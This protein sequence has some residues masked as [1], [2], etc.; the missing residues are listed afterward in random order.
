MYKKLRKPRRIA[1]SKILKLLAEL[2][3]DDRLAVVAAVFREMPKNPKAE[4]RK[5]A[6]VLI[7]TAEADEQHYRAVMYGE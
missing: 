2:S 7:A 6:E 5:M 4:F 1:A 3:P